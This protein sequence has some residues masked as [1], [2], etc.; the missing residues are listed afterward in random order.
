MSETPVRNFAVLRRKLGI[1]A[2]S[3]RQNDGTYSRLACEIS[4][5]Y[6]LGLKL[7]LQVKLPEV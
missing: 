5:A 6:F 4:R 7:D 3:V 1:P 2:G